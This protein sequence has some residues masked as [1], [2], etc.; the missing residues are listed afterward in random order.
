V[1]LHLISVILYKSPLQHY[2]LIWTLTRAKATRT[3]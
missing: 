1:S 3:M 2:F